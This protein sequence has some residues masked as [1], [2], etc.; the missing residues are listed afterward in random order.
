VAGAS[1]SID[2]LITQQECELEG[3]EHCY[4]VLVETGVFSSDSKE[5]LSLDHSPRDFL[6]A[7]SSFQEPTYTVGNVLEAVELI[8]E[9]QNFK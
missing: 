1:R 9:K 2:H 7:E 4:S 3:A 8:F 6:P 5:S